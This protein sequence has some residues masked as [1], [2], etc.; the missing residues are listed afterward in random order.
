VATHHTG[1]G[2]G[3]RRSRLECAGT[4]R[5]RIKRSTMKLHANC[6][7]G[8]CRPL[9]RG[10]HFGSF[11]FLGGAP[12]DVVHDGHPWQAGS[13]GCPRTRRHNSARDVAT[14]GFDFYSRFPVFGSQPIPHGSF[15]LWPRPPSIGINQDLAHY[16]RMTV[17]RRRSR[18]RLYQALPTARAGRLLWSSRQY[19]DQHQNTRE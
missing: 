16:R 9:S 12:S 6:A 8:V 13:S 1:H 4:A 5:G 10:R 11:H 2:S 3:D 17:F 19:R 18:L 14:R 7:G 15:P